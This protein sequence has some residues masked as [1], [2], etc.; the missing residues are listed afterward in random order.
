MS[1][2]VD[3][4]DAQRFSL[5]HFAQTNHA[6][7]A[8]WKLRMHII[9]VISHG[10]KAYLKTCPSHL[11]Q[12][13]N[14]TIQAVYEVILDTLKK[15]G[16]LP[17]TLHVQLD[18]TTKQCKGKFLICFLA[19]LKA[20]GVFREVHVGFLPVGHTHEDIDQ[21]FSRVSLR[22]RLRNAVSRLRL[23]RVMQSSFKKYNKP[24]DVAHWDSVANISGYL[25]GLGC[26]RELEN[27]TS[28]HDFR[29]VHDRE[30]NL[31]IQV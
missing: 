25:T 24:P 18:N 17:P 8:I 29:V 30:Q 5:P 9:G 23:G 31:S 12:G 16:R 2:I 14:I 6:S 1:L 28:Y 10:R 20:A 3:A 19:M 21:L 13:N 27:V 11:A 26:L 22:L 15:E 4:A 7:A